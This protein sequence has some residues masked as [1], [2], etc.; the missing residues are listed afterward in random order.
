VTGRLKAI[1][2]REEAPPANP[3]F[4]D[5]KLLFTEEQWLTRQKEKK[6]Q[7]GS[8]SFKARRRQPRRKSSDNGTD[9]D[10]S[11]KGGERK[12][13]RDDT[14]L[15]CGRRGHWARECRQPRRQGATHMAQAEEEE[16]SLFLTHASLVLR[17]EGEA[18]EGE[19]LAFPHT[20]S[21]PPLTSSALLYI[22]EPR[23]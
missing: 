4:I 22:D 8:S 2:N 1:D 21:T 15:N 6:K 17:P 19:A 10:G 16:S 7:E 3:V 13:T 9:G 11:G 20:H 5:G 18:S 14:C 12:A 23:A